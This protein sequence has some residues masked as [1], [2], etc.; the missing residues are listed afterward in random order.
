MAAE[1]GGVVHGVGCLGSATLNLAYTP[2]VGSFRHMV[3]RSVRNLHPFSSFLFLSFFVRPCLVDLNSK[4]LTANKP[5]KNGGCWEWDVAVGI[6]ILQE[7]GGLITT[8][9]PPQD[10]ETAPVPEVSL[11]SRLYLA[12][13]PAGPFPHGD[14]ATVPKR[15]LSARSGSAGRASTT[16]GPGCDRNK[17]M[18]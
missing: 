14:G 13:R 2:M 10:F 8:A 9:N 3:G 18:L 4:Q 11:G 17:E 6:A 15:G 16:P 12:I 5:P 7:A 1:I